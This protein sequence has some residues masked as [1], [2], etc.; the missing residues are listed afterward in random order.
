MAK[1]Y[2]VILEQSQRGQ[3]YSAWPLP[4]A[5]DPEAIMEDPKGPP[6]DPATEDSDATLFAEAER[7]R[8]LAEV[9][10]RVA[11]GDTSV[12]DEV[13]WLQMLNDKK[14]PQR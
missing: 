2:Q 13:Y 12:V 4:K 9:L 3:R 5:I 10:R 6:K 8:R 7:A 11:A 14:L 1:A